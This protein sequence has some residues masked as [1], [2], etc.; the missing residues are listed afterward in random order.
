MVQNGDIKKS[1]GSLRRLHGVVEASN[2]TEN[3][4]N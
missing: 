4:K 3:R 2:Q 1:V